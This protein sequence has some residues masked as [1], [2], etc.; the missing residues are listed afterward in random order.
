MDPAATT[1]VTITP[2]LIH[3]FR[4]VPVPET[5]RLNRTSEAEAVI[6]RKIAFLAR[7][8]ITAQFDDASL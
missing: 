8:N 4:T 2:V 7:D 5:F 3:P 1:P 6:W